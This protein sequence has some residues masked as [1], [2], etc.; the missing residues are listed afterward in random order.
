MVL[1]RLSLRCLLHSKLEGAQGKMLPRGHRKVA[2][3]CLLLVPPLLLPLLHPRPQPWLGGGMIS[4]R[5]VL[6]VWCV[7]GAGV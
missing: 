6:H 7:R 5:I 1:S 2:K 3:P 4:G